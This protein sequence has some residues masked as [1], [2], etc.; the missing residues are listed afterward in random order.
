LVRARG[1]LA[2]PELAAEDARLGARRLAAVTGAFGAEEVLDR[3]F[4]SFCIGK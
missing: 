1:A 3:V 4:A 2:E